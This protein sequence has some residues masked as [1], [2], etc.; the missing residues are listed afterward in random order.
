VWLLGLRDLQWRRR[1]FLIAVLATSIVFALTLLLAGASSGLKNEGRRIVGS[2]G[3][4][5]WLVAK[6]TSGP[7][8]ASTVLPEDTARE[9]AALPGV[10]RADPVVL[11]RSSVDDGSLRDV[12]VIGYRQGGIGTPTVVDGRLPRRDGEVVADTRLGVDPG[13]KVRV[14]GLQMQVVG[15]A[16]G[17]TYAF[18]TPTIV[19]PLRDAQE[20]VY[21]GQPLASAIVTRGV[22]DSVPADLKVLR[23]DEVRKDLERPAKSGNETIDFLNVLLWLVAAGIIGS[24]VYVSALERVRDFAVLKATG[25][26]SRTLLGVL[27]IQSVFLSVAAALVAAVFAQLLKPS[28]PFE[29]SIE[30]SAY[31]SLVVIALLVGFVASL[32]GLRRAVGVDPAL[33]FGGA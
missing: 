26:A 2:F 9:V 19:M 28:F 5:A 32:V 13:E 20:L 17:I 29:V 14:N 31:V 11:L 16:E 21:A 3:A 27:M 33:A 22:P 15:T 12:N 23:D 6:G 10:R 8:T 24:L 30:A 18:G 4:D 25:V 7:F 1:R